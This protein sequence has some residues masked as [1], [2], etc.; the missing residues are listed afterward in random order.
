MQGFRYWIWK[1]DTEVHLQIYIQYG[2]KT[3]YLILTKNVVDLQST[4]F[5]SKN[6]H[7]GQLSKKIT[8]KK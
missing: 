7:F 8:Q 5:N 2:V 1:Q 4:N 6:L 3:T